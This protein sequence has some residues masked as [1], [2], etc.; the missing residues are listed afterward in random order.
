MLSSKTKSKSCFGL[1]RILP[2][3]I[4]ITFKNKI[5][6]FCDFEFEQFFE[7]KVSNFVFY[8][9]RC[10]YCFLV[11]LSKLV[12]SLVYCSFRVFLQL[13]HAKCLLYRVV[14]SFSVIFFFRFQSNWVRAF[15]ICINTFK[16]FQKRF[17]AFVIIIIII[18]IH[19]LSGGG[20]SWIAKYLKRIFNGNKLKERRRKNRNSFNFFV[21]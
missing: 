17:F 10:F 14:S 7:F 15:K 13:Q 8:G 21:V 2:I 1:S 18:I 20:N 5:D 9:L 11:S 3:L 16:I 6:S 4:W 12:S 19:P